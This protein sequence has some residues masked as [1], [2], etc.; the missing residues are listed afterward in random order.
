MFESVL[1]WGGAGCYGAAWLA[2][3]RGGSRAGAALW[4][5]LVAALLYANLIALRWLHVGHGPFLT[6]FEIQISNL[7]TLGAVALAVAARLPEA[8]TALRV[9]LGVMALLGLWSTQ[10]SKEPIPLPAS[11]DNPWLWVH[12]G[13]GKLFLGLCTIAL[14]WAG[15]LLWNNRARRPL[16]ARCAEACDVRLWQMMTLAFLCHGAMLVAGAVWANDAWGRW[17]AWDP[18]E[19]SAFVT[20]LAMA[21]TLHLRLAWSI[22]RVLG[23]CLVVAIFALAFLTFFGMPFLSLAPHKGLG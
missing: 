22:P 3:L 10:V 23:W 8:R 15:G 14:G 16:P 7:C 17:W 4:F 13:F 2:S 5:M 9:S 6:L 11:F 12:V 21:F 18:L 1:C 20:W 19:T